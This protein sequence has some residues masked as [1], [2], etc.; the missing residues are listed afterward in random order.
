MREPLGHTKSFPP[1]FAEVPLGSTAKLGLNV[2]AGM[3]P[4]PI[5]VVRNDALEHNIAAM[6]EYCRR[7]GLSLAP[8]GKTT[9]SP[10]IFHRQLENG[11]WAITAAT[12]QQA[13]VMRQH[14]VPRVILANELIDP[15]GVSWAASILRSNAG[16]ELF[17]LVDSVDAVRRLRDGLADAGTTRPLQVLLEVGVEGGRAGVRNNN[18]AEGVLASILATPHL[19]LVGVECFEGIIGPGR[20]Q[21]AVQAVDD[22]L[23]RLVDTAKMA[24][25]AGAFAEA[26]EV[27]ITAGGSVFF[28]RVAALRLETRSMARPVRM[29]L[30]SGC[31]V[32]HDSGI[33]EELSPLG[34]TA[35][36]SASIRL[37]PALE[38]WS[39]VLSR[40][41]PTLGIL[42]FGKRDA[43]FD[44]GLPKPL[45]RMRRSQSQSLKGLASVRSMHDQHAML[46]L[47]PST[48]VRVGDHIVLGISHPCTAFDKWQLLPAVNEAYDV[49]GAFR[50]HF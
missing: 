4:S 21:T 44:A 6:A 46:E 7:S 41:E 34:R 17:V 43:P 18:R 8:H 49:I 5:L 47:D 22:L 23:A 12:W 9:M 40:P 37:R 36:A 35:G 25:R 19:A 32:T 45:R 30:R 24:E 11:A 48:D 15:L 50:T 13:E 31:Y 16:F 1:E 2:A 10:Q 14:G 38:L 20:E 33:F 3:L 39:R 29:V 28:D 26:E 27:L 42:D